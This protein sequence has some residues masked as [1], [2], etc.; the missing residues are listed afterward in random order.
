MFKD[1]FIT[2]TD[3]NVGKTHVTINIAKQALEQQRKVNILKP[4]AT[5]CVHLQQFA[6]SVAFGKRSN[7]KLYSED[8]LK[9]KSIN[10]ANLSTH[11]GWSFKESVSP[12]IA[13]KLN[14]IN[15]DANTI[16]LWCKQKIKNSPDLVLIEGAGGLLVPLNMNETWLDVLKILQVPI[17]L[18]VGIRLGCLNHALL[19]TN[20]LLANQLPFV[21]WVANMIDPNCLYPELILETL[22]Q[23]IPVP[24]LTIYKYKNH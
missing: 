16:A 10:H 15:L 12:H 23:K 4:V 17:I 20:V 8:I 6:S 1:I 3:T 21:G 13:A 18:V 5:G 7:E 14:N 24:C 11:E 9:Y 19:T 22:K 2:G